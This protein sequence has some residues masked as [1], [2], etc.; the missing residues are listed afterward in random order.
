MNTPAEKYLAAKKKFSEGKHP[1]W[2]KQGI[3]CPH[4]NAELTPTEVARLL[5][6]IRSEKKSKT[7]AENGKLGGRPKGSKNKTKEVKP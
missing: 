7:S 1:E 4:C 2:W 6:S 5:G 3:N